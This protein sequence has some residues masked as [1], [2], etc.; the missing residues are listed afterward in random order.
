MKNSY[1]VRECWSRLE[2]LDQ[3]ISGARTNHYW[4][5]LRDRR[6]WWERELARSQAREDTAEFAMC[7]KEK[8]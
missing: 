2:Q 1:S 7:E 5:E 3:A 8:P 4:R 6:G